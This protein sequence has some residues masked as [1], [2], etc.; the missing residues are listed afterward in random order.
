MSGL[1]VPTGFSCSARGFPTSLRLQNIGSRCLFREHAVQVVRKRAALEAER[2]AITESVKVDL[3]NPPSPRD[4]RTRLSLPLPTS[5]LNP[6]ADV[7][8]RRETTQISAFFRT[9]CVLGSR[10]EDESSF[11]D[12]GN[13]LNLCTLTLPAHEPRNPELLPF[14]KKRF[15]NTVPGPSAPD[16]PTCAGS[17]HR[18][19]DQVETE[20]W[21]GKGGLVRVFGRRKR[22]SCSG[23]DWRK[24]LATRCHSQAAEQPTQHRQQT[25]G[26]RYSWPRRRAGRHPPLTA[27]TA[28]L[29]GREALGALRR[30]PL[31]GARAPNASAVSNSAASGRGR[32]AFTPVKPARSRAGRASARLPL[33]WRSGP[34]ARQSSCR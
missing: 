31:R 33:S 23:A 14:G 29:L 26:C 22:D 3:R 6:T 18:M 16:C 15:Q 10:Q 28:S 24:L 21:P 7:M 2:L 8:C 17:R 30:D 32:P 4:R 19:R 5:S 9:T 27:D 13:S 34:P 25:Q 1:L 12:G 20:L 11:S